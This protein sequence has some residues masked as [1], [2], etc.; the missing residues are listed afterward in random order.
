MARVRINK[1]DMVRLCLNIFY[2]IWC[3]GLVE[4]IMSLDEKFRVP[5]PE[6]DM[7]HPLGS[8]NL[9]IVPRQ[10]ALVIRDLVAFNKVWP[11]MES[12]IQFLLG[13]RGIMVD[14]RKEWL[15]SYLG[16][17]NAYIHPG[18]GF[19]NLDAL[20][21]CTPNIEKSSREKF[22]FEFPPFFR[23]KTLMTL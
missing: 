20:D 8:F 19:G 3:Q 11:K 23:W 21:F 18:V 16:L 17:F 22:S 10:H 1:W 2:P 4:A 15:R 7:D 14:N 6:M 13:W 5:L 9:E 12:S